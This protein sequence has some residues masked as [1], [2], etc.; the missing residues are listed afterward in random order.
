MEKI[1]EVKA[2]HFWSCAYIQKDKEI[3][4]RPLDVK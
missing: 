3:V 4:K 1:I 2:E